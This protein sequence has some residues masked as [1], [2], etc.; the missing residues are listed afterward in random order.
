ML[1]MLSSCEKPLADE[2]PNGNT[3]KGQYSVTFGAF[4]VDQAPFGQTTEPQSRASATNIKDVCTRLSIA[5][6]DEDGK[7]VAI[8]N[9]ES[10]E[11]GFG[12]FT[13]N[14]DEGTYDVVAIAHNGA[15]NATM[16]SPSEIK[17]KDNKVTDTF[18]AYSKVSVSGDDSHSL[19]LKRAVAMFRLIVSDATPDDVGSM[20]FYYTGGS[21]TFN[22]TT[23]YGCVN[24][25]QTE[26]RTV[27]AAAHNASSTYEAYTFP[28]P[29]GRNLKIEISAMKKG[30]SNTVL[31]TRTFTDVPMTR[32]AITQYRG[33]FYD[34]NTS[35]GRGFSV[36]I[37]NQWDTDNNHEYEY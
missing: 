14:L 15:G 25:K 21:S 2:T 35:S 34:E 29:D 1:A 27:E 3:G 10:S 31:H 24:S 20:K 37:D 33:N 16:T 17:F 7:R 26:I 12:K 32:N 9:K 4:S 6:F 11:T 13:A 19:T 23:G 5:I 22:A 36:D 18:Y 8:S 28:H 30:D